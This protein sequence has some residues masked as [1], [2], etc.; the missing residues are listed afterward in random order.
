MTPRPEDL[1]I[2][3]VEQIDANWLARVLARPVGAVRVEPIGTGQIGSVARVVSSQADVAP[4]LVKLPA[5]D[6]DARALLAGPY[7]SEVRFYAELASS[8]AIRVPG[9]HLA[10]MADQ[11]PEFTLVLQDLTPA[12]PGDQLAGCTDQQALAAAINLAGLHGPRWCDPR[13]LDIEGLSLNGA[14]DA[15]LLGQFFAEATEEFLR[16]LAGR[17]TPG[18]VEV[19]R[20]TA[21]VIE[22]WALGEGARRDRFALVHG[23]YR[24]DNL[25]FA[26]PAAA[27][28]LPATWAVDW[29]TLSLGLPARDLAF[30]AG[31]S[32]TPEQ[33]RRLEGDLVAA[34]HQALGQHGVRG[35][36]LEESWEDYRF[37]MLQG[38]LVAVFGCAYGA[39]TERGDAMFVAMVERAAAAIEELGTLDLVGG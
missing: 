36:S 25:M 19:L 6:P 28:E 2:T 17:L 23:D 4:V 27:G 12:R 20:A 3:G 31:T 8:V 15:A 5:S 9:V 11:G 26:A 39:R 38:P 21:A 34:H 29:Q 16:R 33:R 7:R 22:R 1:L 37:A 32:L 13:L 14:E 24:A 30:L 35:H 10:V 18:T